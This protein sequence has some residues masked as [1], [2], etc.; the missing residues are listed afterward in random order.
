[1][2]NKQLTRKK[3]LDIAKLSVLFLLTSCNGLSRKISIGL[4][5]NFLPVSF[6]NLLPKTWKKEN[7]NYKEDNSNKNFRNKDL[8]LINDGWLSRVDLKL[9]DA[10]S[11]PLINYLDERS[12]YYLSNWPFFEQK[13][14]Y[15]IAVIPY[16]VI[17]K[18][19]ERYKI[20][21]KNNWDFLL[22]KDLIG[23]MILPNSPRILISIAE[24]INNKNAMKAIFNKGNIY[25]DIN[26]ID[27][28]I[29]TDAVLAILPLTICEKYLKIDSRLSI[30]FPN[31]GVPLMWNFLLINN[32]FNQALLLDWIDKLLD[33]NSINKLIK[34]GL[35]LPF[36]NEYIQSKYKYS[37]KSARLL[38]RPSEECW[39]NSWSFNSLKESEKVEFEK[40]WKD[41]LAP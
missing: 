13:K 15:P 10:I 17:I 21:N 19:N 23:K 24:R 25:D 40:I 32:N 37:S 5:K 16:A 36:N 8:I 6:I 39:R 20:T 38:N 22:S 14:L 11:E 7:L 1:M 30:V 2:K 12:K 28:L 18:N 26:A 35:Y 41:L 3:F 4:Y 9:F 33:R 29:N 31:Q 27:W 34:D